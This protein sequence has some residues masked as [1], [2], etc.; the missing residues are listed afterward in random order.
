MTIKLSQ[1][2]SKLRELGTYRTAYMNS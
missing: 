1:D 2:I